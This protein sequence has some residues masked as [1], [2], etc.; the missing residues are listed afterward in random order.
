MHKNNT[1]RA[2]GLAALILIFLTGMIQVFMLGFESGEIYPAYSSLRSDPLG[3]R[4]LYESLKNFEDVGIRRNYQIL[5]SLKFE[6]NTTFFYLGAS[7]TD[8]DMV[9]QELIQMIDR[10]MHSGGRLVLSFLPVHKESVNAQKKKCSN[11]KGD[12]NDKYDV[13][14]DDNPRE[15]DQTSESE[16]PA[17]DKKAGKRRKA[18]KLKIKADEQDRHFISIKK[19]WGVEF[20]F[21]DDVIDEDTKYLKLSARSSRPHLPPKISWHTNLFFR[22]HDPGWQIIYS[23]EGQPAIIERSFGQG[24]MVLCADSFFISNEALWSERHPELL[25]WLIGGKTNLVFDEAHFGIYKRGAVASLIRHYRFH[26]FFAALIVLALLFVW[27]SAVFFV[28]PRHDGASVANDVVTEKDVAQGLIALLRRNIPVKAIMTT[29]VQEW[30]KTFKNDRRI[31]PATFE[32]V[33]SVITG[34]ETSSR[35][36]WDPV[37]GYQK[38]FRII[39]K[40]KGYE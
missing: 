20:E 39:S 30:E 33:K 5:Q 28:P 26:W 8:W 17:S 14:P 13:P 24:T 3:S 15:S 18:K 9:P 23:S 10:L 37:E 12:D 6:Q 38:I 40:D 34:Q 25:I 36:L 7:E 35:Q 4:A 19:H 27:K 22:L 31:A 16:Y 32:R 11:L 29:C 21:N 2:I 1:I